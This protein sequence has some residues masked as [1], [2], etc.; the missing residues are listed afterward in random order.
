MA[1]DFLRLPES[2]IQHILSFLPFKEIGRTC[3]L[4]KY[5]NN[6]WCIYPNL[7]F[8]LLDNEKLDNQVENPEHPFL[9]RVEN[10]LG[11]C[12]ARRRF[13]KEVCI[14]IRTRLE[15]KTLTP[16]LDRWLGL[17][18]DKNVS[19][20][21]LNI[22]NTRWLVLTP[23][24]TYSVPEQV[25]VARTLE[26]LDLSRC[27]IEENCFVC[28]ELP[29]LEKLSLSLCRFIG[30]NLLQKIVCAF[31]KMKHLSIS[32]CK[33]EGRSLSVSCKSQLTCFF[34]KSS[35]EFERVQINVPSLHTF[36]FGSE[37]AACAIDVTGCTNLRELYLD[38]VIGMDLERFRSI[39]I[40]IPV[41]KVYAR[42]L[43]SKYKIS[44]QSLKRLIL[45]GSDY[46]PGVE[47]DAPNLLSFEFSLTHDLSSEFNFCSWSIPKVD[48]INMMF[49]AH[50]F[51]KACG[52]GLEDFILKLHNYE[53]ANW[54]IFDPNYR[55]FIMIE[56]LQAVSFSSLKSFARKS[57]SISI[58]ISLKA[59]ISMVCRLLESHSIVQ[60]TI[61]LICSSPQFAECFYKK[62]GNC[63]AVKDNYCCELVSQSKVK[64][65]ATPAWESFMESN[66][67]G[68][69]HNAA[70]VLDKRVQR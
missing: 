58:L 62:L 8:R 10:S 68:K 42:Y 7:N 2:L 29:N 26:V 35:N 31:P 64:Q 32:Q 11:K 45:N 5:W 41:L 67:R 22:V 21:V 60:T 70:I 17:A 9:D 20:L 12:L 57:R 47:I 28:I 38:G 44:S 14:E 51:R 6:I 18:L 23:P 69:N 34:L 39:F 61:S 56:K 16:K 50:S 4:S 40:S 59:Q 63:S 15:V 1:D 37:N 66:S 30:D 54:I 33:G 46:F 13:I 43:P 48:D 3:V 52:A 25:F 24:V 55:D 36:S 27:T 19:K 53:D 49:S 65:L